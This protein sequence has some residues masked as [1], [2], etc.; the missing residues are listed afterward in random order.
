M[1]TSLQWNTMKNNSHK[2]YELHLIQD[3][4]GEYWKSGF[5]NYTSIGS[6]FKD[7]RRELDA[8]QCRALPNGAVGADGCPARGRTLE[9]VN[10]I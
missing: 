9:C 2:I 6:G 8:F 3:P 10:G 1:M 5:R 4:V 7:S